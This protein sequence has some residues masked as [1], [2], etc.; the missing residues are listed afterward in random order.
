MVSV[1]N[2]LVH[3][4]QRKT[5]NGDKVEEN[6]LPTGLRQFRKSREREESFKFIERSA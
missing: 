2:E 4:T 1:E 6:V 3:S 5:E